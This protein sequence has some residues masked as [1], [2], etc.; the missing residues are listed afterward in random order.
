MI[1]GYI[2]ALLASVSLWM[3][4]TLLIMSREIDVTIDRAVEWCVELGVLEADFS[5]TPLLGGR[6]DEKKNLA[7]MDSEA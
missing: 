3:P 4:R 1:V 6:E 5:R 2:R 7:V